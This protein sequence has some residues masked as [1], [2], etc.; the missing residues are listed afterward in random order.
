MPRGG[1]VIG[2]GSGSP[3]RGAPPGV[4]AG[5]TMWA[6]G[7]LLGLWQVPLKRASKRRPP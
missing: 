6:P 2:C 1:F 4:I 7:A 5:S 3:D